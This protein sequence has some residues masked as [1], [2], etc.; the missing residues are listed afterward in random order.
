MNV[1]AFH[2]WVL[3]ALAGS[4]LACASL[5][6]GSSAP[7]T[8]PAD[9]SVRYDWWEGSLPPPYHY[10]FS[11]T[12]A[13]DG[14]GQVT[15]TPDYPSTDTPTW[16]ETFALDEAQ[17][18]ALYAQLRDLGVFATTW[19]EAVDIPVGGSSSVLVITVEGASITVPA[20]P[21]R[22][23]EQAD[24]AK[25]AVYAAVPAEIWDRLS[26]QRD[27]YVQEHETP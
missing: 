17:L 14:T 26:A 12:I 21:E 24:A 3:L 13:P 1:S 11:V 22:A 25:S 23:V 10:Q 7:E 20:F 15:Y 4:S 9:F 8:R 18:D 19:R 5:S 16:V 27:Q 2:W 6:G